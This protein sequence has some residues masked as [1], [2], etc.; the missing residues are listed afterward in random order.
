M[1]KI[2]NDGQRIVETNYWGTEHARRGF[3]Y[4]SWNAG[5]GRLL[6]PDSARQMLREMKNVRHV[7]VSRGRWIEMGGR[8]AL[9]L[10]FEDG[11][12]NP[13]AIHLVVQQCDRMIPDEQ[14][15]GGFD[16]AIWTPKG[17]QLR[18][19]GKYRVVPALPCLEKW[20]EQ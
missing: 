3:L 10:L 13:F 18:F 8:D 5:A 9:E 1:L 4:L 11:S 2:V 17:E 20:G 16:I 6:V 15:G 19:P 12:K 7:I 14:Q